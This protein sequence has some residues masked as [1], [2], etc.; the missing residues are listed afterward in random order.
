MTLEEI[1]AAV[2]AGLNVYWSN[3]GYRVIKDRLGRYLIGYDIDG[4]HENYIG[5]THQDGITL[6]G[7]PEEFFG[8]KAIKGKP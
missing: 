2:D 7:K 5:L 3:V 8:A 4:P 1:K 6:N